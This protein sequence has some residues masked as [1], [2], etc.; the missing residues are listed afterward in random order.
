[1]SFCRLNNGSFFRDIPA[2]GRGKPAHETP[3]GEMQTLLPRRGSIRVHPLYL[4]FT[5]E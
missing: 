3:A 1:M 2:A 4:K 5:S